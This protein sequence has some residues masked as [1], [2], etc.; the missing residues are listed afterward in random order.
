M[1]RDDWNAMWSGRGDAAHHHDHDHDHGEEERPHH[2]TEPEA[3]LVEL[4]AGLAPGRALDLGC[5]LGSNAIWLASQGWQV[6]AVDFAD[7]ALRIAG[8]RAR[9]DDVAVDFV[10]GDLRTYRDDAVFDLVTLFYVHFAGVEQ[11]DLLARA[12]AM[13]AP[14]GR[15]LFVGH[16]RSDRDKI[17]LFLEHQ[18]GDAEPTAEDRARVEAMLSVPEEVAEE[19]PGLAIERAEVVLADGH[20]HG[21]AAPTTVVQAQRRD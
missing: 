12:A 1:E 5:G 19:F 21:E 2:G 6:R 9:G 15:L 3:L 10:P 8:D 13:V 16:D 7:E 18:L 20:G 14:G 11:Q 4:A 17:D